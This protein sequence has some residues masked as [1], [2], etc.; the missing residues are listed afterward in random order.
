MSAQGLFQKCGARARKAK[1]EERLRRI[2]AAHGAWERGEAL[3]DEEVLQ[4]CG[5]LLRMGFKIRMA[6]NLAQALPACV[7][8]GKRLLVAA[9]AI[10]QPALLE[11]FGGGECRLRRGHRIEYRQRRIRLSHTAEHHRTQ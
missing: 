1:H 9:H 8:S 10:E 4:P 5:E 3:R 11:P 2:G 7:K 6:R